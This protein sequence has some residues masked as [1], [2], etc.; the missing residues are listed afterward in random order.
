MTSN[1]QEIRNRFLQMLEDGRHAFETAATALVGGTDP[2]AIRSDLFTTDRRINETEQEL[3]RLM[4]IHA[5]VHG[6]N[7]FPSMLALMSIAKDAERIGDY[8]KNIFDLCV[9]KP[10]LGTER[11][12]LTELR[13]RITALLVEMRRL[14]ET[15]DEADSRKFLDKADQI[16]NACDEA[17]KRLLRMGGVNMASAALSYRYF[18]RVASHAANIVTSIVVPLDKLDFFDEN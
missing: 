11:K 4:L 17:V 3:R 5:T 2:E 1:F 10:Q 15:E 9:A 6:T 12:P 13:D 7:V 16:E 18:K 14:H 8:A